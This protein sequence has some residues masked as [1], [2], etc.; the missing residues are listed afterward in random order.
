MSN[1]IRENSI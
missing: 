1:N